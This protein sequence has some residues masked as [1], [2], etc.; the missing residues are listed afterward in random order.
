M[1]TKLG[2][3]SISDVRPQDWR[4]VATAV[5]NIRQRIQSLEASL[6]ITSSTVQ[7]TAST[8]TSNLN[9]LLTQLT[10]LTA[11]IT[12]LE[13]AASTDIE[14]FI[15]GETIA[16]GQCIVPISAAGV[17]VADPSDPSRMFGLIGVATVAAVL[18]ATVFV[19][20]RGLYV[21]PGA[22]G[23]QAGQAVYVDS[24]GGITQTPNY[25]ATALPL[26]VAVSAT[27]IF[28]APIWPALLYP[29]YSSGIE[30]AYEGYLPIT[31]RAAQALAGPSLEAQIA[32]L[33]F[34]SGLDPTSEIPVLV[35][36]TAVR[37][38]ASDLGGGGGLTP[39]AAGD[40]LAN[41]AGGPAIPIGHTVSDILNTLSMQSGAERLS[42][43]PTLVGGVAVLT[44][45]ED[46]AS[47]YT[48]T[49]NA[50]SLNFTID[51]TLAADSDALLPTE[52]AVKTYADTAIAA[53]VAGL[54]WKQEVRAATTVNGVLATAYAVG[55]VIDGVT[56]AL[57]DRILIKNQTLGQNNGIY[58]VNLAGVPTRST[59][60]N[61]GPELVSAA[62]SVSEGTANADTAWTCV[63]IA[64]IVLGTTPLVWAAAPAGTITALN[65]DVTA[66]GTGN[67]TATLAT[68]NS[69]VG[70]YT[71]ASFTV[72]A[73]GLI[74]AA[75]SPVVA[76]NLIIA[77][78]ASGASAAAAARAIVSADLP[79]PA[80]NTQIASYTIQASDCDSNT[81]IRMNVATANDLTVAPHSTTG[82]PAGTVI[83][84]DQMGAGITT[85]VAGI[86]V[87]L[88]KSRT[89]ALSAQFA[90]GGMIQDTIDAW[91]VFGDLT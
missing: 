68:V 51:G 70:P 31:L 38:A 55:S 62:C 80:F 82:A 89:L 83:L 18:G 40:L 74:T 17:G 34:S 64:P 22:S 45:A 15:A 23:F 14:E 16:Q 47:L 87:S 67:V 30:D 57:G 84:F 26:G 42:L 36:S 63:T 43:V 9:T 88:V 24:L 81:W 52:K 37:V 19:Q 10:Q 21:V 77:G 12:A 58:L 61:T 69:N 86:G 48:P 2:A 90:C 65:G 33:P 44:A 25:D 20:R 78:P 32:A 75:S 71:Y 91:S 49:G 59:D 66:S 3:P 56:L 4:A 35:G 29:S 28:I 5:S 50:G 11:R 72:N 60:A 7:N 53:A 1:A 41:L 27:Q 6:G 46:I 76:A 39:I 85:V 8:S 54:S 79:L 73:K 13:S